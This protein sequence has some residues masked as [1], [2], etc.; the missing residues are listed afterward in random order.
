MTLKLIGAGLGRTGTASLK[1]AL[2]QIGYGP[3]YH[4]REVFPRPDAH[5]FWR[6]AFAQSL[7]PGGVTLDYAKVFEGF[8]STVDWP[9]CHFWRDLA[10]RYPDAKVLLSLRDPESWWKSVQA[11]IFN[12]IK[13]ALA[14]PEV[15][16]PAM[17]QMF[18]NLVA[19]AIGCDLDDKESVLAMFKR[20]NEAVITQVP[21]DRLLVFEALQGWEPLCR[22]LDVPVPGTPY[23]KTNTTEDFLAQWKNELSSLNQKGSGPE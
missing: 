10:I 14:A 5:V 2:E 18:K 16:S 7:Q 23:P 9:A 1:I 17:V 15:G 21:K 4:M 20:H 3:C 6:D 11:T 22:F 19:A 13:R 12:P 8:V